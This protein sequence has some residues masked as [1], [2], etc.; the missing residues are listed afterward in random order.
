MMKFALFRLIQVPDQPFS[1]GFDN[2]DSQFTIRTPIFKQIS[3]TIFELQWLS[4]NGCNFISTIH[5]DTKGIYT[6][7]V[8]FDPISAEECGFPAFTGNVNP[9]GTMLEISLID[10]EYHHLSLV[11]E[12]TEN[13]SVEIYYKNDDSIIDIG[14]FDAQKIFQKRNSSI[15]SIRNKQSGSGDV[16]REAQCTFA[17]RSCA[18]FSTIGA[19][20]GALGAATSL[21]G[22]GLAASIP[23][24]TIGATSFVLG[25]GCFAM[26]GG[27]PPLIG[28]K[29]GVPAIDPIRG[30]R[31]D[32][33]IPRTIGQTVDM[34]NFF[35][36]FTGTLANESEVA[37]RAGNRGIREPGPFPWDEGLA[38]IRRT[39]GRDYCDKKP[40]RPLA[41][42]N[43]TAQPNNR[44]AELPGQPS[45]DV[46]YVGTINFTQL[47]DRKK[48]EGY[49]Y[50]EYPKTD[51]LTQG[52]CT[53]TK[54]M[55]RELAPRIEI[56][57][58]I[59]D[60]AQYCRERFSQHQDP[61]IRQVA[62]SAFVQ[63]SMSHWNRNR[64]KRWDCFVSCPPNDTRC[65]PFNPQNGPF[66]R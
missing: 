38:D 29:P 9:E 26:F 30:I 59:A 46:L 19:V 64:E 43:P 33:A 14:T 57:F 18:G 37:Y 39:L 55:G 62:S 54:P 6:E 42:E 53:V 2:Q 58:D 22:V 15:T 49:Y 50:N 16:V 4:P 60:G 31:P 13:D 40:D 63:V 5:K 51:N 25:L 32:P 21:T 41:E 48:P 65:S 11:A 1:P 35:S 45:G 56:N 24:W 28:P 44:L 36:F 34:Y 3:A 23:L 7:S 10:P 61:G 52:L 47:C 66:S 8:R 17:R 20:A 12:V 27:V